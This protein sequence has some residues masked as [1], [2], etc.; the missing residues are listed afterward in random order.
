MRPCSFFIMLIIS[1][2]YFSASA[3]D[4]TKIGNSPEAY[5]RT[6]AQNYKDMLLS[7]CI[8]SA[9]ENEPLASRDAGSTG[10]ALVEWTYYDAE[11]STD[12]INSLLKR[13]L[14]RNYKNPLVEYQ[15]V[16]FGLL[17]CLD[18][19]HSKEL[20]TQVKRFVLKP[21]KTYLQAN[22]PKALQ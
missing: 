7:W 6:N 1:L 22:P 14:S 15:D 10:S 12:A 4:E 2:A 20:D 13:Y 8:S 5:T 19:Y 17:K 9:Y 16:K 18:M 3:L 21:N 11:N